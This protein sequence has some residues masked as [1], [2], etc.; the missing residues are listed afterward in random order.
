MMKTLA[1][2]HGPETALKFKAIVAIGCNPNFNLSGA[3]KELFTIRPF[4]HIS[5]ICLITDE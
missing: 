2:P 1:P 5:V 4:K 3:T